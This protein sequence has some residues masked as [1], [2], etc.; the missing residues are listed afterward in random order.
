MV[1]F[2]FDCCPLELVKSEEAPPKVPRCR[3]RL[4]AALHLVV[5]V[6]AS[7]GSAAAFGSA[8]QGGLKPVDIRTSPA[9]RIR[10]SHVVRKCKDYFILDINKE[11]MPIFPDR[12]V[13]KE[14][15][16]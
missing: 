14:L 5:L 7:R 3:C 16:A 4:V 2:V 15:A 12:V 11:T 8:L 6:L 1:V 13:Q 9:E 10:I